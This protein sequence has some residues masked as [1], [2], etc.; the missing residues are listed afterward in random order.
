MRIEVVQT[1]EQFPK[2]T[3]INPSIRKQLERGTVNP[4]DV[5]ETLRELHRRRY[6]PQASKTR[7]DFS[8]A[9]W[10]PVLRA[11][12][13]G[14]AGLLLSSLGAALFYLQRNLIDA[15]ILSLGIVKAYI[16]PTSS[17]ASHSGPSG[18]SVLAQNDQQIEAALGIADGEEE[19]SIP[20][21][22]SQV[23]FQHLQSDVSAETTHMSLDGTTLHNLEV[24]HNS[25]DFSTAGSLWSV[26]DH[27]KTP[28]GSRLLRAW[29]L[30]PLFK[31]CDID[32]RADAVQELVSGS[33]AI[34]LSEAQSILSKC[35]DIERLL[36]RVHSMSG[37]FRSADD[38]ESDCDMTM[39]HP[40]DRAVLYETKTYTKRK[41][42]DFSKLLSSLR[43]VTRIPEAFQGIAIQSGLLAK[44]VRTVDQG[45]CFPD[46]TAQL[47]WFYENFDCEMAAKGLYEPA[48]GIDDDYDA[49]CAVIERIEADLKSYKS[50][51]CTNLMP[52]DLAK[53]SWKYINTSPDSKDKYLIELSVGVAVP[54]EF[55]VKGKRGTGSKQVNKYRTP[56]VEGLVRELE[57]ALEVQKER[58]AR[59]MQLLFAKFDSMRALWASASTATALLDALGALA[60][61]SSCPGYSRPIILEAQLGASSSIDVVQ[62]RHP[63]VE[64]SLGPGNFVPN[65]LNLGLKRGGESSPRVLLLSGVNMGGKSTCLRQTCL[66]AILAQIGCF[67]PAVACHLTPIDRIYTRLGAS[68]RILLGQSTFFVEVSLLASL[69]A[70]HSLRVSHYVA[71]VD[72]SWQKQPPHFEV[73]HREVWSSW[74]SSVE[75]RQRLTGQRLRV[76]RFFTSLN[77]QNVLAFLL[78]ITIR[79]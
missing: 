41:V 59:G 34:A 11:A 78:H 51:M 48:T 52:R 29:L 25:T 36:A 73:P 54:E 24:L 6:Y 4:W 19:P 37:S 2:S 43:S 70:M 10:P 69:M 39:I 30:R 28:H 44:I 61:A 12:V 38:G 5:Q 15:E 63:C 45:G 18:L 26:I 22:A 35:G 7:S 40:N 49:A 55:V 75:E 62:G 32:R 72:G 66:I 14:D 1:Q 57:K 8:V 74:T 47:D 13:E 68:D 64:K 58:K 21:P 53:S 16:P 50:D 3:A 23:D 71:F 17:V 46:M 65:D 42:A 67:V 9:R 33:A 56:T 60:K 79:Y 20:R 27:T 77:A 76:R 31:K